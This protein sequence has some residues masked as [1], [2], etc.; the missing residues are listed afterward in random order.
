MSDLE[1]MRVFVK[2]AELRSFARTAEALGLPR[3][4]VSAAVQRLEAKLDTQLLH[5][6]TRQVSLSHDGQVCLQRCLDLLGDFDELTNLFR[7]GPDPLE[8][9]VRVGTSGG[10]ARIVLPALPRFL[11]EHP[12][13]A[14]EVS[15]TERRVDLVREGFDC[16]VRVGAAVDESLIARNLG[17]LEVVSCASASYVESC[18]HPTEPG[19][20]RPE[21]GHR[22]VHFTPRLGGSRDR[23]EY[24]DRGGLHEID[25]PGP[26]TVNS[27]EAYVEACR[28]GL[29]II[30]V[31][32]NAVAED[33]AAGALVELLPDHPPDPMPV[34]LLFAQRRHLPRRVQ[35]FMQWLR[36]VLAPHLVE[37]GE[38]EGGPAPSA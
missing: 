14:V 16:V 15:S 2:V 3:S 11:A 22:M 18:G 6:T 12:R 32:R 8:G 24:R 30:Q 5:R 20:L 25:L 4:S 34:N 38:L 1:A 7:P 9:R 23:F 28:A 21:R 10:L 37:R 31:P 27:G 33:L 35:A 29:G 19:E 26:L 13:L 17:A 36:E